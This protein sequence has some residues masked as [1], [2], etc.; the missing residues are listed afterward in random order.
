LIDYH[1]KET[2]PD[3]ILIPIANHFLEIS[4]VLTFRFHL[5]DI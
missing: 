1:D 5:F 2:T 4:L 3:L